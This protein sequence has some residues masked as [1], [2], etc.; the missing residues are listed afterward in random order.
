MSIYKTPTAQAA[1]LTWHERF[2]ARLARP[3]ES[4][5]FPTPFGETHCLICG[6]TDAPP[7]VLLHGAL[8]SSAH[9]LS[10]VAGLANHFRV[11]ALDVIG[12]SPLSAE[13]RPEVD[14]PAYGEWLRA[15]LDSLELPRVRLLGVSWGGF[16]ALRLAALAPERIERLSL[17]VPAGL[18][19]NNSPEAFLKVGLPMLL[20][21]AFPSPK[22][23][24]RAVAQLF[25]TPDSEWRDYLGEALRGVKLDFRA[26]RPLR[27]GALS[28]FAAPVQVIA[29]DGDL[30]FPGVAL[31]TRAKAV[32]PNLTAT[33]LLTQTRHTPAFTP[34]ARQHLTETILAFLG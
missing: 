29:A 7:L 12:Q 23:L 6:P 15:C 3:T 32:F 20:Y 4:R 31:L 22:R 34:E 25:T 5:R 8:A 26:P 21:T 17:I 2:R 27:D 13:T 33:E 16:I 1:L 30:S 14:G 18:V 19:Q 10:E 11:Y 24:E 28:G 9:A